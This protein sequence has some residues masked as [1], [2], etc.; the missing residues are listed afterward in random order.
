M[1]VPSHPSTG[2]VSVT[3]P[4]LV[5]GLGTWDVALITFGTLVGSAIFIAAGMVYRG[6][7]QPAVL[8]GLWVLGGL[9]SI[10]GVLTYAELGTM[11][12]EAGGAYNYLKAAYGPLF[13]FLF[14]WTAF[15]VM[16]SGAIAFLAVAS[17]ERLGNF[18]PYF[19]SAHVVATIPLGAASWAIHGNQ[20]GAAAAIAMLCAINYI[21]LREGAGFQ[22]F[23]AVI[24][25]GSL[26]ALAGFGLAAPAAVAPDWWSVPEDIDWVGAIG[27]AMI[28]VLWCFDG[29]YQATFCGGEIRDPGRN[30]PRGM[31]IGLLLTLVLYLFANLVYLRALPVEE[32]G[33]V[34]GVGEASA[35]ALFGAHWA[36]LITL[37]VFISIFGCLASGVLTS[38]R[39]YLP[40][41][42]DGL[43]F[44]SLAKIHP[45]Y[46]TPSA[47]IVAQGFWSIVLAFSGSYEQL[48][49]YVVFAVYVFHAATG[50]AVIVLRR[51]QP[52]RPRPYRTWGYPWTP[53][54]F[55]LVA[56]AFVVSTLLERPVESLWGALIVALGLPAYAWWRRKWRTV[57]LARAQTTDALVP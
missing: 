14:G 39:I 24:K 38:S 10:A 28:G 32:L 41:A 30:L 15:F 44:R 18:V 45:K 43:F 42:Q 4:Q 57:G 49:T 51:T 11:F 1:T 36:P 22:N 53:V 23:I 48:G 50:A 6:M 20:I 2:H 21:G 12:P 7:P 25:I 19:S 27:V 52:D 5:R 33:R 37:A 55:V 26:V 40:M 9:L 3:A 46:R 54:V 56:L 29:F 17:A 35:V 13:G 31:I 47:C 8:M 34:N 16:Q